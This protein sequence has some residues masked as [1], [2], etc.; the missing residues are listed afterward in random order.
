MSR[1]MGGPTTDMDDVKR[2]IS[3]LLVLELRSLCCSVRS[4]SLYRLNSLTLSLSL[5]LGCYLEANFNVDMK[6]V[7]LERVG[8]AP[9]VMD[10]LVT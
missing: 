6:G 1:K 8:Q 5:S 10:R 2:N 3:F 9:L 7:E 4:Q